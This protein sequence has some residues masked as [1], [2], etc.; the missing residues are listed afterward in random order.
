MDL[1]IKIQSALANI[2]AWY[3]KQKFIFDLRNEGCQKVYETANFSIYCPASLTEEPSLTRTKQYFSFIAPTMTTNY[4][5]RMINISGQDFLKRTSSMNK[6]IINIDEQLTSSKSFTLVVSNNIDYT[7]LYKQ[8]GLSDG[9]AVLT[10]IK[11]VNKT[12]YIIY[13]NKNMYGDFMIV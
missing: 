6:A 8:W 10:H 4:L 12:Y 13:N 1:L 5:S 9:G 3:N 2:K 7:D 11:I